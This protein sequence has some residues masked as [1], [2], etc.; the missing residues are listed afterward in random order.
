MCSVGRWQGYVHCVVPNTALASSIL[1]RSN[2]QPNVMHKFEAAC[3]RTHIHTHKQNIATH[4]TP[5]PHLLLSHSQTAGWG[6]RSGHNRPTSPPRACM[7]QICSSQPSVSKCLWGAGPPSCCELW[8]RQML[9]T[10]TNGRSEG[11]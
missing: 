5:I 11:G 2:N 8:M 6:C 10:Q 4:Q 7:G 1:M 3:T 9:A